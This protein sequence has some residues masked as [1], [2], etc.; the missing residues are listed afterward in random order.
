MWQLGNEDPVSAAPTL[1]HH[2]VSAEYIQEVFWHVSTCAEPS[3]DHHGIC[4]KKELS[5]HVQTNADSVL[6]APASGTQG[7]CTTKSK[8]KT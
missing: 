7:I 3:P 4:G 5:A 6:A 1:N 8:T 2:A